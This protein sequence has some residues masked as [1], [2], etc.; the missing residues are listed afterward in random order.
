MAIVTPIISCGKW[1]LTVKGIKGI[2]GLGIYVAQWA[3]L[4]FYGFDGLRP[5]I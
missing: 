5:G 1:Q 4:G 3:G 2:W